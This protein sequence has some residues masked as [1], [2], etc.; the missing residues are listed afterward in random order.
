MWVEVSHFGWF[1]IQT[2][3]SNVHFSKWRREFFL[4]MSNRCSYLKMTNTCSHILWIWEW[5]AAI[6]SP[7]AAEPGEPELRQ[8]RGDSSNSPSVFKGHVTN[9]GSWHKGKSYQ[10]IFHIFY[11]WYLHSRQYQSLK[12][13]TFYQKLT[14]Q[15][16]LFCKKLAK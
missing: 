11:T 4:R 13:L 14:R 6:P 5:S 2:F 7:R 10:H 9:S 16:I 12:I 3:T 15:P 1:R 8:T